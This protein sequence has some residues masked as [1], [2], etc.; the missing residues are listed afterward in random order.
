MC[1]RNSWRQNTSFWHNVVPKAPK[2]CHLTPPGPLRVVKGLI[3]SLWQAVSGRTP[4][5]KIEIPPQVFG[6][7]QNPSGFGVFRQMSHRGFKGFGWNFLIS[8][9]SLFKVGNF[10]ENFSFWLTFVRELLYILSTPLGQ[11]PL[12]SPRAIEPRQP[13]MTLRRRNIRFW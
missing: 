6:D 13:T 10:V 11:N 2:M 4:I 9:K 12:K 7:T 3:L 1:F 5:T 8:E